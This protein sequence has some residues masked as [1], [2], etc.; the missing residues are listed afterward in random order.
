MIAFTFHVTDQF[1]IK[2]EILFAWK[3]KNVVPSTL[4]INEDRSDF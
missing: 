1:M 2:K 3:F 4:H